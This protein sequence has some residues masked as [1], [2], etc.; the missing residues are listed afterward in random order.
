MTQEQSEKLPA[1]YR[2]EMLKTQESIFLN[3][4]L[5][6][7]AQRVAQ[8]FANSTMVPDHF[9][10][11]LGN[12]M[13]ALN[14]AMRIK[15]DPFMVMQSMYIV[16]GR[17]GIEGKLV[18]AVINASGKYAE[19]LQYVWLDPED[20][21]VPRKTV[22]E[23]KNFQG[24]GCQA[25]TKDAKS[26]Q[27]V[28][29]PKITW[30]LVKAEGWYDKN[31]SKWQ[32][33]P[34]MMFIYRAASWFGNK[35]CP[36]LKLGMATVEELHDSIDLQRQSNGSYATA[37]DA[38]KKKAEELKERLKQ[39][40]GG[41]K[42]EKPASEDPIREQYINLRSAGFSTWVH[43]NLDMIRDLD[44]PYREEIKA[45]WEKLY[46]EDSYPLDKE[47]SAATG[48]IATPEQENEPEEE[49]AGP[50]TIGDRVYDVQCNNPEIAMDFTYREFC[51]T[52]CAYKDRKDGSVCEDYMNY[53]KAKGEA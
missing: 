38:T 47:E 20:N 21:E 43:K 40:N 34:E 39:E 5:F 15:A 50:K 30:Q 19:P 33:M 9:Q 7:Q 14:Y 44:T 25:Y 46:P 24:Y 36:E 13:I 8:V 2:A 22:L 37:I 49:T 32:T 35:N 42:E 17:P 53:L 11:N 41:E 12:C 18:E 10:K 45:K 51:E 31:G 29:G 23:H 4:A 26:G 48:Q 28:T 1:E 6:E 27:K 16:H 3:V 52:R